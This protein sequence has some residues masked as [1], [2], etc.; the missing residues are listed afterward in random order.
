[1]IG[2]DDALPQFSL[3]NVVGEDISLKDFAKKPVVILFSTQKFVSSLDEWYQ[4]L[5]QK[6]SA[7]EISVIPIAILNKLPSFVPS[8]AIKVRL[9]KETSAP[10]L[11]D[12]NGNVAKQFQITEDGAYLF[13]A[14]GL[15]K[16]RTAESE[17][18]EH[19]LDEIQKLI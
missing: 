15:H 12:I 5:S 13:V 19:L 6:F 7:N 3:E 17:L 1:M 4:T 8:S 9:K 2:I 16:V 10:I 11:M 18:S 14:D